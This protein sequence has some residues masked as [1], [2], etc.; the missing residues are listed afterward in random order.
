MLGEGY[1]FSILPHKKLMNIKDQMTWANI[2]AL[3][4]L[5]P[6]YNYAASGAGNRFIATRVGMADVK[7][8]FTKNDLVIVCWTNVARMDRYDS[9]EDRWYLR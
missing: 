8:K 7:H 4:L 3:D 6:F 2:L 5:V 1:C 9:T